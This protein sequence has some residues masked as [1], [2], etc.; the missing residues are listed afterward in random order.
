MH[1]GRIATVTAFCLAL[2]WGLFSFASTEP[3]LYYRFFLTLAGACLL[4][5][6]FFRTETLLEARL[7]PVLMLGAFLLVLVIVS[8]TLKAEGYI[9][10]AVGWFALAFTILSPKRKPLFLFLIALG[11]VEAFYGLAQAIGGW[12]YIGDY[13]RGLGSLASGTFINRNHFAGFLNMAIPLALGGLYATFPRKGRRHR[14]EGYAW[15]WI[16]ILACGFMGL[17]ILLSQSRGGTLSLFASIVFLGLLMALRHRTHGERRLSGKASSVLL[18]TV[19]VLGLWVG[20]DALINRF[21]QLPEGA[22]DRR[23]VYQESIRLIGEHPFGLGPAMYQW[24]FRPYQAFETHC[25]YAQAHN[26]YLQ[27]AAEWGI[28]VAV[29][30]WGFVLWRL[31]Q[32]ARRFLDSRDLWEQGVALGCG[33]AILSI[34]LHSLVDFNLQIPANWA[35]FCVVLGLTFRPTNNADKA[36]GWGRRIGV[37]AALAALLLISGWSVAKK[38][39]ALQIASDRTIPAYEEALGWVPDESVYHFRLGR[40]QLD[41]IDLLNLESAGQHLKTAIKLNPFYWRYWRELAR[42][43]EARGDTA[44]TGK[45]LLRC[46]EIQPFS[47][48]DRWRLGNFYIRQG[49]IQ[50]ALEQIHQAIELDPTYRQAALMLLW[51]VGLG[52]DL[53]D[54][55]WPADADS[56]LMLVRFL[57][58][59][60]GDESFVRERWA[61]CVE[62]IRKTKGETSPLTH[63]AFYLDHLYR[64]KKFRE[65]R[66]EWVGL[67]RLAGIEDR[68]FA[69]RRNFVWNGRFQRP[70]G[71]GLLDW[72]LA[73]SD[74][75]DVDQPGLLRLEFKGTANL[76]FG[77]AQTLVL[78][79]GKYVFSARMKGE[80]LTTEEGPYFVVIGSAG[81]VLVK[82]DQLHGTVPITDYRAEFAVPDPYQVVSVQ[83]RRG[84]SKRIDN[85]LKGVCWVESVRIEPA[86]DAEK[87]ALKKVE[88]GG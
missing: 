32:S 25:W 17:A 14:S 15:A 50:E 51:R 39:I 31:V 5:V 83:M 53:V 87:R 23:Q 68:E 10:L 33:G 9:L 12:D 56:Q 88:G 58:K 65:L 44:N 21:F 38:F 29:L 1:A 84:R 81:T 63:G 55:L 82:T 41:D 3:G 73:K 45:A 69:S 75:Y 40:L 2:A 7:A 8:P 80:D 67:N 62:A 47:A 85:K 18:F 34:L 24:H 48:A 59:N 79:A 35:V 64:E 6:F 49:R 46:L 27:T 60:G 16:I 77:M 71:S 42:Y 57:V 37:R 74:A 76:I 28:V 43:H 66:D 22:S 26:D 11:L 20:V 52:R 30:F 4:A 13:E 70:I 86:D 78:P 54:T 72:S 19:L 61:R 36:D